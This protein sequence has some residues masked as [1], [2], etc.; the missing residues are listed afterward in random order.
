L[1]II[2]YKEAFEYI[3]ELA[4]TDRAITERTIKE[5]H[6]LVL[7]GNRSDAGVYRMVPI[8]IEGAQ[9]TPTPPLALPEKMSE[10]LEWYKAD[11]SDGKRHIIESIAEFHLKFEG[12]HPF[13]D[14]NGRT[15]RLILNLELVKFGLLPIDI[16]HKD[17]ARYYQGFDSYFGNDQSAQPFI[18]M[19]SGY[20]IVELERYINIINDKEAIL[21]S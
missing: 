17:I 19:V 9:D 12:V 7:M 3:I 4:K 5:I 11:I 20:Q 14:G 2:G 1:D 10:L 6:R 16:K 13:I 8:T 15:G 21:D 18:D